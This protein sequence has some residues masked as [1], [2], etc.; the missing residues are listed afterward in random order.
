MQMSDSKIVKDPDLLIMI[1]NIDLSE[2]IIPLSDDGVVVWG[3][4]V[5]VQSEN[6][7]QE[8]WWDSWVDDVTLQE[9]QT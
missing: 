4:E 3:L 8:I 5:F 9:V 7:W 2:M 6:A 1:K